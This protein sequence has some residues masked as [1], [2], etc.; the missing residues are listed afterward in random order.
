MPPPAAQFVSAVVVS[1]SP[2][3]LT[4]A[5]TR[6]QPTVSFV[7]PTP[8]PK[9]ANVKKRPLVDRDS[10]PAKTTK[11]EALE[12]SEAAGAYSVHGQCAPLATMGRPPASRDRRST[13]VVASISITDTGRVAVVGAS[14][15]TPPVPCDTKATAP[16][17]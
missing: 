5:T 17:V 12:N 1:T 11:L 9:Q 10:A 14:A 2:D 4:R 13:P 3:Q 16:A 8:H 7:E 15:F 6:G